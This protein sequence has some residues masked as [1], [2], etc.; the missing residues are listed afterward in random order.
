MPH[1]AIMS[2]LSRSFVT[3]DH[4]LAVPQRARRGVFWSLL[5]IAGLSIIVL[6][7][8]AL[9]YF[10]N[11]ELREAE[12][13]LSLYTRSLDET[14]NRFQHLPYVLS[15]DP[16]IIAATIAVQEDPQLLAT[17][18]LKL[19]RF[20]EEA[21]LEAIYLMDRNGTVISASN[22]RSPLTFMGQ[23]YSFRPYFKAAMDG[24]R[25][26]FFGVGATTGR[27]GYFVSQP[28]RHSGQIIGVVAIKLDMS[29]LQRVWQQG[30]ERV[31]A[32]NR[33]RIIV[34]SSQP[35]WL[36]SPLV[37]L[38]DVQRMAIKGKR[39]FGGQS[40]IALNWVP[41]GAARV[42]FEGDRYTH[43]FASSQ[44]LGW[45]VHYLRSERR[46]FE[47]AALVTIIFGTVLCALLAFA[48]F[49]RS[50][51]IRAALAVAQADR[52]ALIETNQVL[53]NAQVELRA[54]SKLAALGTLAASVT[55]ELGQPISA[56]KNYLAAAE[57]SGVLRQG[58]LQQQLNK[59]AARM[60]GITQQLRFFNQPHETSLE[61]CDLAVIIQ[62]ALELVRHDI[63]AQT[64]VLDFSLPAEPLMVRCH[65]LRIEQVVVNLLRNA[66]LAMQDSDEKT[67]SIIL[68]RDKEY[69][70]LTIADTGTGLGGKALAELTEPFFSTRASGEGMG[71]GLSISASI[72]KDH[73][74]GFY[75]DDLGNGSQFRVVLA[76]DPADKG[77]RPDG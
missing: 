20:A 58:P 37:Q 61:R 41:L 50:E 2:D 5:A 28:L 7:L 72:I 32:T 77:T 27:P 62:D 12:S 66:I 25:G 8:V 23:N 56:M 18:N 54:K 73:D 10:R 36:Y 51:R 15:Q 74:G 55:H 46:I 21:A 24:E 31:F 60:E 75:A 76:L 4:A 39:Q 1:I 29:E 17:L 57:M 47:R 52:L 19:E 33:D 69:A 38:N 30:G 49:L 68:K 48:T 40:L 34:V 3:H 44:H 11:V 43:V 71:L 45:V 42:L 53:E 64:I 59:V 70:E 67:L 65:R 6:L 14:L 13:R 9:S 26:A 22:F 63:V 35:E 16:S